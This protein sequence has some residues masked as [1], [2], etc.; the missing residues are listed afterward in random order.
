M[1][2]RIMEELE[3]SRRNGMNDNSIYKEMELNFKLNEY[4][5]RE[6]ELWKQKSRELWLKV[7]EYVLLFFHSSVINIRELNKTNKKN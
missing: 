7:I 6:E 3:E 5:G 2:R 1:I 4:L